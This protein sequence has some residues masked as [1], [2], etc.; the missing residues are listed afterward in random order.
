MKCYLEIIKRL[1]KEQK[2]IQKKRSQLDPAKGGTDALKK[3]Y[4]EHR[5]YNEKLIKDFKELVASFLEE[6]PKHICEAIDIYYYH[7]ENW[8][9]V[10]AKVHYYAGQSPSTP[11]KHIEDACKNWDM[12]H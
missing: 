10:V 11:K 9:C 3:K 12:D 4:D 8:P 6:Q 7:D 1:V 5:A 2:E